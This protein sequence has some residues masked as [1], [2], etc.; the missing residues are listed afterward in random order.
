MGMTLPSEL[1]RLLN[2]LGFNWPEIDEQRLFELGQSWTAYGGRL[3][4]IGGDAQRAAQQGWSGNSGAAI[5]AFKERW[6]DEQSPAEILHKGATAGHALGAILM[7]CAAIVL[8]LKIN[9]II[10]LTILLIQII[11]AIATAGPT[12]GASLAEIPVFKAI[13]QMIINLI[14]NEAINAILGV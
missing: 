10:Q 4:Q 6:E 13:Q 9:V 2:D 14:I 3:E 1:E 5:D 8:A 11:Q 7:V 12:F